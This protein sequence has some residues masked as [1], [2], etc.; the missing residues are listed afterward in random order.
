MG[1]IIPWWNWG[2]P[3]RTLVPWRQGFGHPIRNQC[4]GWFAQIQWWRQEWITH[5]LPLLYSIQVGFFGKIPVAWAWTSKKSS[6][7]L[8][9][10][11]LFAIIKHLFVFHTSMDCR[12]PFVVAFKFLQMTV[13]NDL[14]LSDDDGKMPKSQERSWRFESR[15]WKF[16]STWRKT[17]QV[18]N[19]LL[20]FGA[21]LSAFCLKKTKQNKYPTNVCRFIFFP[22]RL[23]GNGRT[24]IPFN[25]TSTK[26]SM[27]KRILAPFY[28]VQGRAIYASSPSIDSTVTLSPI[29]SKL[30]RWAWRCR[31]RNLFWC[32]NSFRAEIEEI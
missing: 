7:P 6:P 16:L 14:K 21:S 11:S 30:F 3:T 26:S 4:T 15:L 2:E 31:G 17:C 13:Q 29:L 27:L 24:T 20:C 19:Y 28:S 23:L 8:A 25:S 9:S 18:I 10:S 5:E 1:S 32:W 22:Q 12:C